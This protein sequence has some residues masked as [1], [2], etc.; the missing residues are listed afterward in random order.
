MHSSENQSASSP[1][2]VAVDIA[3]ASLDDC[4]GLAQL[5]VETWRQAYAGIVPGQYLASLSV[6]RR[7]DAWR[8]VITE[9]NSELLVGRVAGALVGLVS[10]GRSRDADA[11]PQRGELWAIYV[12]PSAWSTGV[13]RALWEAARKRLLALGLQSTS[14]WVLAG[15]V[16]AIR[17]YEAAGFA[18]DPGSRKE[19]ELG[20]AKLREL[21]MVADNVA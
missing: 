10:F 6:Q 4:P 12:A 17:F 5:H 13:G 1:G 7:E 9:G 3:P 18:L 16:R 8:Q 19:F 2:P 11:P 21:R 14:L 20:G 15:N